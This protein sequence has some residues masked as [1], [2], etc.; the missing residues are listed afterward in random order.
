METATLLGY[1]GKE[2]AQKSNQAASKNEFTFIDSMPA[3]KTASFA[4]KTPSTVTI[5]PHE[6]REFKSQVAAL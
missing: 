2:P 4:K 3:K 5:A 1:L 6:K